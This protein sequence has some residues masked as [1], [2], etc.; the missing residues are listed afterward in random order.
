[1]GRTRLSKANWIKLLVIT[2]ILSMF[3]YIGYHWPMLSIAY[4]ER[5]YV[6]RFKEQYSLSQEPEPDAFDFVSFTS[7]MG[8]FN[9]SAMLGGT[10][11]RSTWSK[12]SSDG[13]ISE[14]G[15][16][17]AQLIDEFTENG[18]QILFYD[19][20]LEEQI[21]PPLANYS[22]TY[23]KRRDLKYLRKH[24]IEPP[25]TIADIPQKFLQ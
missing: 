19:Y 4:N 5:A 17:Q 10:R 15:R 7:T 12:L 25:E 11:G 24:G 13:T 16:V 21:L 14:A 6:D 22:Y 1:M 18:Y 23:L 3:G 9:G 2:A 20:F 8:I